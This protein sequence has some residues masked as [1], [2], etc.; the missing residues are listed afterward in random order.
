MGTHGYIGPHMCTKSGRTFV[1]VASGVCQ[2]GT[3]LL[4]LLADVVKQ[5][6][7]RL[8]AL[9]QIREWEADRDEQLER[10]RR[11]VQELGHR[12]LYYSAEGFAHINYESN[13]ADARWEPMWQLVRELGIPVFWYL[14]TPRPEVS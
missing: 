2:P 1:T 7:D 11:Q 13:L 4:S 9:A 3:L 5:H 6:P 10:L 14:H 8:I 12:G